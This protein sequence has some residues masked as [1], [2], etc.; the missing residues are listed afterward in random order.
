[1]SIISKLIYLISFTGFSSLGQLPYRLAKPILENCPSEL[2][3]K[4]ELEFTEWQAVS[5]ASS[6]Y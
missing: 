6:F 3:A 4:L 2:L 5:P 1:M